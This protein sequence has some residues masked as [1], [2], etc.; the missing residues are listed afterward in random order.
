[1][2]RIKDT[3]EEKRLRENIELDAR[4]QREIIN[5]QKP[6]AI[7]QVRKDTPPE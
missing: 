4:Y 1:M 7:S 2:G 6:N 5:K 3:I